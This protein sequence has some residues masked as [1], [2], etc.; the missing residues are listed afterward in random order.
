MAK[1]AISQEGAAAMKS[2]AQSLLM[3]ANGIIEAST[4]LVQKTGSLGEGLGI[5]GDEILQIMSKNKTTLLSNKEVIIEL[6]KK[7][8]QQSEEIESLF[9]LVGE[10]ASAGSTSSATGIS[11]AGNG[12]STSPQSASSQLYEY[13]S[14]WESG[15]SNEQKQAINDYTK[16]GPQHYRNI[17]AVLRGKESSFEP[18][19][20]ERFEAIHSALSSASTPCDLTVYRGGGNAILGVLQNTKDE[21]LVGQ[22]FSDKGFVSTSME[23][24]SA[25]FNDVLLEIHLPAGSHAANIESLSAAGK[26]EHE[27]LMDCGQLFQVERVYREDSGRRVVVVRGI[28]E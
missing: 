18:G 2:L 17:N 15:L 16:E 3:S 20:Q 28:G 4:V 24:S 5:Y 9:S 22:F 19:N 11:A 7:A 13:S 10:G 21:D 14:Q 25:F 6:A 23:R 1:Y 27:V 12:I 8:S 26:Y